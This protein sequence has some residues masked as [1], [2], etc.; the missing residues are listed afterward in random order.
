MPTG[1]WP[2]AALTVF[3][4]AGALGA[5]A[6]R[7]PARALPEGT[8][9]GAARDA[10]G[11]WKLSISF[12]SMPRGPGVADVDFPDVDG[13]GRRFS[14]VQ[15]GAN[16]H[17]ERRQPNGG[18]IVLDAELRAGSM[19]GTLTG[20]GVATP[21]VL[22][23]AT[24]PPEIAVE[25]TTFADGTVRLAASIYRPAAPG[26]HPAIVEIHGGGA[27]TRAKYES[28]ATFLARRGITTLI[29][30]KRG[31]GA[32]T[33]DWETASMEELARDALAG[34][35][36]LR[37]RKGVDPRR[38][39]VEGFSQGGWVAP[40]AAS[41]DPRVAFVVVGSASGIDPVAQS[42]FEVQNEMRAAGDPDSILELATRLRQRLYA[43]PRGESRRTLSDELRLLR[44]TPWFVR[45]GLP[46]SLNA[47]T[48][49][50]VEQFLHFDPEGAWRRVHVPVLAYWGEK[51]IHLPA[52][53]SRAILARALSAAGN[54]DTSF[55]IYPGSD[56]ALSR[57]RSPAARGP[58]LPRVYPSYELIASWLK[59]H[60]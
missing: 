37:A 4:L 23:P 46:D 15:R 35:E 27:D 9:A 47:S 2:R 59:S 39:G 12:L 50:G 21:F 57:P 28:K 53:A 56:H 13:Y 58:A 31:T 52:G 1:S 34:A 54:A 30:D 24:S 55:V 38:V 20:L 7:P 40:L 16:L 41:L 32:S 3:C 48:P 22:H 11:E 44:T 36:I 51:D 25:S 18:A 45:S 5:L 19:V 10:D 8:W 49:D 43:A 6:D 60:R 42:V 26:A 29:Y 17:M 14:V 33:G